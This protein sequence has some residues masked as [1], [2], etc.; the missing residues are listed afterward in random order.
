MKL[1][2]KSPAL[3]GTER[4]EERLIVVGI[5]ALTVVVNEGLEPVAVCPSAAISI[6]DSIVPPFALDKVTRLFT[7]SSLPI[8]MVAAESHPTVPGR[9]KRF[10]AA[11][12]LRTPWFICELSRST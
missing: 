4:V 2:L 8:R 1:P 10:G 11:P 9:D 5:P 3:L 7:R 6:T 12:K